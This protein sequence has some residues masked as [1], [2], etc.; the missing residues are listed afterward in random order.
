MPERVLKLERTHRSRRIRLVDSHTITPE[1]YV[2][3]SYCWGGSQQLKLTKATIDRLKSGIDLDELPQTLKDAVIVTENLNLRLIWVD[4]LCIIQDDDAAALAREIDTMAFVYGEAMV[5][6]LASRSQSVHQG[7]LHERRYPG[8]TFEVP[9]IKPNGEETSLILVQVSEKSAEHVEPLDER[10]WALQEQLLSPRVIDFRTYQTRYACKNPENSGFKATTDGW[11]TSFFDSTSP[12]WS[13]IKEN[14]INSTPE[15]RIQ[16]TM[17]KKEVED[18][19]QRLLSK[20]QAQWHIPIGFWYD[21][22]NAY[23]QRKL[24]NRT[25]RL[26]AIGGIARTIGSILYSQYCAGLW[27]DCL[28]QGLIWRSFE[29]ATLQ[30]RPSEYLGPS[31]SW[32]GMNAA[33]NCQRCKLM[34]EYEFPLDKE[35]RV[36]DCQIE[37][38]HK[39]AQYGTVLSGKLTVRGRMRPAVWRR[40][41]DSHKTEQKSV[42]FAQ[43]SP[44]GL[45]QLPAIMWAD[46]FEKEFADSATKSIPVWLLYHSY[47]Q[48]LSNTAQHFGIVLRRCSDGIYTRVGMFHCIISEV[49]DPQGRGISFDTNIEEKT[50]V[51]KRVFEKWVNWIYESE[52]VTVNII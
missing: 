52:V 27:R 51:R 44:E 50:K 15:N 31:W 18:I 24:S 11:A 32:V 28:A 3:L 9:Y 26:T 35:F 1:P 8:P 10:A 22:V 37:L 14:Y 29:G 43:V 30:S 40:G 16:I 20:S 38:Q 21:T 48:D 36:V 19:H 47:Q 46:A 7:F 4:V 17:P 45:D 33:V 12:G 23:T 25:D 13:F 41:E 5:T 6:L 34:M 49:K 2:A 39:D 42:L